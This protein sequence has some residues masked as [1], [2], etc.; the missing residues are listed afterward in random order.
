MLWSTSHVIPFGD[1]ACF[2]AFS[3]A[4]LWP[5]FALCR[6]RSGRWML[7][8]HHGEGSHR[9]LCCC[10]IFCLQ[11][12][13]HLPWSARAAWQRN[14][15]VSA[16]LPWVVLPFCC[17]LFLPW[18]HWSS[19]HLIPWGEISL[20]KA[21]VFLFCSNV[22]CYILEF[23]FRLMI[24]NVIVGCKTKVKP[25]YFLCSNLSPGIFVFPCGLFAVFVCFRI[26]VAQLN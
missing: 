24:S 12:S 9:Y 13:F 7:F 8:S 16:Y 6:R 21:C 5:F 3:K 23:W 11:R 22:A 4:L 25:C 18:I 26:L 20:C 15:Q 1:A 10:L 19:S 17:V 2:E 14:E